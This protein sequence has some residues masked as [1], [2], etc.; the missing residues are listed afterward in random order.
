MTTP[1][2]IASEKILEYVK[3][4]KESLELRRKEIYSKYMS[5]AVAG[6]ILITV[7]IGLSFDKL[8]NFG[9]FEKSILATALLMLIVALGNILHGNTFTINAQLELLE[10]ERSLIIGKEKVIARDVIETLEGELIAERD[11]AHEFFPY[12]Y[13]SIV[14]AIAL[15]VIGFFTILIKV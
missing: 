7:T 8:A 15:S 3:S 6:I 5:G 13:W 9:L 14:A 11:K 12:T 1:D 4:W 10:Y 2:D